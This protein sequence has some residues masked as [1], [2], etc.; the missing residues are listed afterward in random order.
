MV[1]L[2]PA[3]MD[4]SII[5]KWLLPPCTALTVRVLSKWRLGEFVGGDKLPPQEAEFEVGYSYVMDFLI[6]V[7]LFLCC[8]WK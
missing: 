1:F 7:T 6:L 3:Q 8:S 5:E 4:M 2:S